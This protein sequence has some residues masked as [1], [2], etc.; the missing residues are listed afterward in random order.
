[1]P[2]FEKPG[3]RCETVEKFLASLPEDPVFDLTVTSPPYDIGKAYEHRVPLEKY[4]AWQKQIITEIWKRT[5]PCGSIC[6]QVG[7]WVDKGEI[8]PLDIV[9][10]PLFWELGMKMRNR[11]VWHF[12][13]GTHAKTRFILMRFGCRQ[14]IRE[15]GISRGNTRENCLVIPLV[16]IPKMS[17]TSRMLLG[18]MSR[19]RPI[20]ANF[21][22]GWFP[23]LFGLSAILEISCSTLL[24]VQE[25]RLSRPSRRAVVLSEQKSCQNT[26]GLRQI[27]LFV[28]WLEKKCGD[29]QRN[30]FTTIVRAICPNCRENGGNFNEI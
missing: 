1:M 10:T 12:G 13:H 21:Q 24:Q 6:W 11:I 23:D 30:L 20:P 5:K 8:R 2:D 17:G 19:K 9:L 28:H 26:R 25:Q 14:N 7:N 15:N 22:L 3:V 16:R 4:V 29:R 27:A 18:I